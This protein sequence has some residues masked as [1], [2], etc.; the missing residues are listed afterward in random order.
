MEKVRS[1]CGQPLDRGRLKNRTEQNRSLFLGLSVCFGLI[2]YMLYSCSCV[3][4]GKA[5]IPQRGHRHR[6]P[7]EDRREEVGAVGVGA[8][9]C[10]LNDRRCG[11]GGGTEGLKPSLVAPR[12]VDSGKL[13]YSQLHCLS[14]MPMTN[15]LRLCYVIQNMLYTACC[16]IVDMTIPILSDQG[17]MIS[18]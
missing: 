18:C 6:H 17:D 16:Q 11:G 5:R 12:D 8:V 3:L 15:Y 7:R 9:E 10:E 1:R 2:S 13:I 4:S 14:R